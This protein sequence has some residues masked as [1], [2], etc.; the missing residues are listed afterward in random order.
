MEFEGGEGGSKFPLNAALKKA[1]ACG[2]LPK[3]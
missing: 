3:N 2:T 1:R